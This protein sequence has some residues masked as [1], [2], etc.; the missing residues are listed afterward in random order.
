MN[1][2][3]AVEEIFQARQVAAAGRGPYAI[4]IEIGNEPSTYQTLT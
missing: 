4:G 2:Y 1:G 3:V